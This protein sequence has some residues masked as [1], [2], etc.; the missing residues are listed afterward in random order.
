MMKLYAEYR[1]PEFDKCREKSHEFPNLTPDHLS[2]MMNAIQQPNPEIKEF[3][4][5][6]REYKL[7]DIKFEKQA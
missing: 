2:I 3:E 4:I 5:K 7:E 1:V 6:D